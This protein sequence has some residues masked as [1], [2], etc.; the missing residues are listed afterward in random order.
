MNEFHAGPVTTAVRHSELADHVE[1]VIRGEFDAAMA[2]AVETAFDSVD[3]QSCGG[4]VVDLAQ[5]DFIDSAGLR[6][7]LV[8]QSR[9]SGDGV[10]MTVRNPQR[11]VRRVFELAGVGDVLS[12]EPT[13]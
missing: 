3:T 12:L 4:V 13:P 8:G 1:I 2:G 7:L 9:L 10:T 5:V 11:Q 6:V